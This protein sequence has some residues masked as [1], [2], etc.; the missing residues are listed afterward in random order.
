M[1]TLKQLNFARISL[2]GK[3]KKS[4]EATLDVK[5]A[6]FSNT[7]RWNIGHVYASMEGLT[8]RAVP[9]Y[10]IV[11]PQWFPLFLSG[12]SPDNW[13][14]EPPTLEELIQALEEQ[15]VR[16]TAVLENNLQNSVPEPMI[17]GGVHQMDTVEALAQFITWHEGIHTGVIDAMNRITAE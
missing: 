4:T 15:P 13:E 5:P 9:T 12:T 16:I 17:I 11:N 10:E 14:V 8:K 3:I 2:L 6:G 7:L 1:E